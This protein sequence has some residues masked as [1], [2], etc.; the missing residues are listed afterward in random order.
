MNVELGRNKH[1]ER[2]YKWYV[3]GLHVFIMKNAE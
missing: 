2:L 1:K 3:L